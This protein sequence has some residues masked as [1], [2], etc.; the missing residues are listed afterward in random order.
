MKLTLDGIDIQLSPPKPSITLKKSRMPGVVCKF[1]CECGIAQL[2]ITSDM[3][4]SIPFHHSSASVFNQVKLSRDYT[5][6]VNAAYAPDFVRYAEK[7]QLTKQ[8]WA[9]KTKHPRYSTTMQIRCDACKRV[10]TVPVEFSHD[11]EPHAPMT[12]IEALRKFGLGNGHKTEVVLARAGFS[13]GF[14]SWGEFKAH[15]MN[16][17]KETAVVHS[18]LDCLAD[19]LQKT[20]KKKAPE[21]PMGQ[22]FVDSLTSS[23]NE[24]HEDFQKIA[25]EK[26]ESL[27]AVIWYEAVA[28]KIEEPKDEEG[29]ETA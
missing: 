25:H 9:D 6:E 7:F 22:R 10:Y 24:L 28:E 29:G 2:S 13:K 17:L 16:L 4:K 15:L 21:T 26:L 3:L 27:L 11:I 14:G 20:L 8:K 1:S 18:I 12:N 23:L 5:K 19:N